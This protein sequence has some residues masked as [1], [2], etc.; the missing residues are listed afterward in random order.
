MDP[1]GASASAGAV[2]G[3]TGFSEPFRRSAT[4]YCVAPASLDIR[5]RTGGYVVEVVG[6]GQNV[7]IAARPEWNRRPRT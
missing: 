1:P 3:M 5:R 4:F 6:P 7:A 2:E